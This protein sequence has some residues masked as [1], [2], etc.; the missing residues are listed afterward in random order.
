M[1]IHCGKLLIVWGCR[2]ALSYFILKHVWIITLYIQET[3]KNG[4]A[5][6]ENA[7]KM[8][9]NAALNHGLH[10]LLRCNNI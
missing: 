6:S 5:N 7:D 9:L 8:Q 3:Y 10:Y 4:L 1:C 2:K